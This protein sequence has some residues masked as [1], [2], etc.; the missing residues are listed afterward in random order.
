[1]SADVQP[2]SGTIVTENVARSNFN[3]WTT[4]LQARADEEKGSFDSTQLLAQQVGKIFDA[5]TEEEMDAADEG[6]T[7]A[8]QDFTD[9]IIEIHGYRLERD[10]K[11]TTSAGV[12]AWI[13]ATVQQ[14]NKKGFE[15]GESITLNSGAPLVIAKLEWYRSHDRFPVKC[16]FKSYETRGGNT[17]IKLKRYEAPA[18]TATTA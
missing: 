11:F 15:V 2:K 12:F 9:I 14:P 18:V 4:N 7:V 1:M 6:G 10:S 5:E 16:Y 3:R 8:G 13:D 17:V